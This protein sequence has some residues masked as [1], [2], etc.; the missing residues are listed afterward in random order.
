MNDRLRKRVLALSTL[1]AA[2]VAALAVGIF[3]SFAVRYNASGNV[4]ARVAASGQ[5]LPVTVTVFGR[6]VDTLSARVA[7]YDPDGDLVST[8]ERSWSGWELRLDCVLVSTGPGW[9]VFP[10]G[11]STDATAPGRGISLIKYYDRAGLPA[12]YDSSRLTTAERS[13]LR[14]LYAIVRTERWIPE[15][16]GSL[17]HEPVTIRS[18]VAGVEYS[19]YVSESG[20][21]SLVSN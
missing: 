21:L 13:A 19:L 11:V 18:F 12:L 1:V 8:I 15:F 9:L 2:L 5:R 10:W 20:K 7:F 14:E 6:G 16:F 17:R 4:L 3:V